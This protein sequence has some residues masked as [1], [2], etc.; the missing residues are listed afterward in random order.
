[1][2]TEG[3][4]VRFPDARGQETQIVDV[5]LDTG[6]FELFVN[7]V[8]AS[9]DVPELCASFGSYNSS[10]SQRSVPMNKPFSIRYGS[11]SASGQ[12]YKDDISLL[13]ECSSPEPIWMQDFD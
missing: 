3:T 12:Y 2:L 6:S 1:M 9:S 8:C 4:T 5:L 7:P 10:A 13:R 11:G